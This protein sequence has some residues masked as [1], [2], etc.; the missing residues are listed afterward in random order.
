MCGSS[1]GR[2]YESILAVFEQEDTVGVPLTTSEV[3]EALDS[4]R[5]TAYNN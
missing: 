3:A 2:E 4:A 5:R 1:K